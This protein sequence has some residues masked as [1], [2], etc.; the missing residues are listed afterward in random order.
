VELAERSFVVNNERFSGA[1]D[2]LFLVTRQQRDPDRIAALLLPL[3][4]AAAGGTLPKISHYG[5]YATLVFSG[6]SNR[7]KE[8]VPQQPAAALVSFTGKEQP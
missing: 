8:R 6:G 7:Y 2:L 5:N 3:S 1:G 4:P